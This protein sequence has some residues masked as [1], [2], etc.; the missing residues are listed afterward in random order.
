M[1]ELTQYIKTA[2]K[3]ENDGRFKEA[4]DYFYKALTI[5]ND[6]LE[7][8]KE[9]ANLYSKLN[10]NE[11]AISFCEQILA[12]RPD[13]YQTRFFMSK[14]Y[15]KISN[16]DK[17]S[18]HLI[19][20]LNDEENI[21][22]TVEELYSVLSKTSNADK[23]LEIYQQY[24]NIIVSGVVYYY[25]GMAYLI[26]DD[27]SK[28]EEFF[29][30]SFEMDKNNTESGSR[31]AEV[32][33]NNGN[34]EEA[35]KMLNELLEY[36]ENDRIFYLLAELNYRRADYNKAINYYLL[37]IKLNDGKSE[38]YYKL[39]SAYTE[40]G[41]FSQAEENYCRAICLDSD[42]ILYNYT[43]AYL[44]FINKKYVLAEKI[45]DFI[46][47]IDAENE[48]AI[49]L[50]LNIKLCQ[51]DLSGIGI[52]AEKIINMENKTEQAYYVLA[53]YYSK[54]SLWH[55]AIDNITQAILLNETSCDY[56]YELALYYYEIDEYK[57]SLEVCQKLINLN[58]K[59]IN[60]Y[61]L[62]AKIY[63]VTG[64]YILSGENLDKAFDLDM[65]I[66][67]LYY[68]K[69]NL[70]LRNDNSYEAIENYKI[71]ISMSPK[72]IDYYDAIA[73]CYYEMNDY[74]TAYAYFKEAA[75]LDIATGEYRY[76]MAK[77]AENNG[78]YNTAISN[79]SI[80]S[81]LSPLNIQY[82]EDYAKVLTVKDKKKQ[83]ISMI[84]NSMKF[85]APEEKN[86]L[87]QLINKL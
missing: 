78:D 8:M 84:K 80:A 59:Y 60:A 57:K 38:Y 41:F 45:T 73:H 67:E 61:V 72:S 17:A 82:L 6:S 12:K 54:I 49:I 5:D 76:Y 29:R 65:N 20:L 31:V 52:I 27:K 10:Q 50:K 32:L 24:E 62:L 51:D 22:Q 28:A 87:K 81:R 13:D 86:R 44:Y 37:A 74:E 18:D 42:N 77:C 16:Y 26:K 75:E 7:I 55:K 58:P 3:Y 11:R 40:K 15:K 64:D 70:A 2:F 68:I 34:Y 1:D 9:L 33:F 63:F 43:L 21:I 66:P 53:L 46:L 14:L 47:T 25:V 56:N 71:A 36:S 35:E 30:K 85:V 19:Y 39:G 4:I 83:A 23:I 69:G 48:N 79:Y